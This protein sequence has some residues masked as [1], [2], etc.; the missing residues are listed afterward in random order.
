MANGRRV[1]RARGPR[2]RT[3]WVEA[4][5]AL[6][7]TATGAS[8][9][10]TATV[11]HEG[12]TI[13]R[14]RGLATVSLISATSAGDGYFGAI[15]IAIVTA[16]AA[17]TGAGAI[18]T[19]ITEAGWDGWLLHRYLS[20]EKTL[21]AGS[22]GEFDRAILDSKAMRKASE[23]ENLVIVEEFTETGTAVIAIQVRVRILSMAG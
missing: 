7:R 20:A 2:R 17:A 22:P 23:D 4:S 15:G 1:V 21:G 6:T 3:H 14:V 19:P 18:P 8:I 11:G 13:V 9:L 16:A 10:T 5:G 12:E